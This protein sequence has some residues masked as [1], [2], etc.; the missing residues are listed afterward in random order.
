MRD[1]GRGEG[2]VDVR[3]PSSARQRH[4]ATAV[5]LPDSSLL[6]WGRSGLAHTKLHR[7]SVR[8][9]GLVPR[10]DLVAQLQASRGI[11]LVSV[12]APTGYGKTTLLAQWAAKDRRPFAWLTLDDRDND[13]AVLLTSITAALDH[14]RSVDPTVPDIPGVDRGGDDPCGGSPAEGSAQLDVATDGPRPRQRQHAQQPALHQRDRGVV[15]RRAG[16]DAS[17]ARGAKLARALARSHASRRFGSRGRT[18]RSHDERARDGAAPDRHGS[19]RSRTR[20]SQHSRSRR[21]AGQSAY[22][23]RR[24]RGGKAPATLSPRRGSRGTIAS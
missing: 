3:D 17:S 5:S 19:G 9:K 6:A 18:E 20:R 11:P 21:R 2:G 14:V 8:R 23:S 4:A 10:T 12:M 13:P 24:C 15:R 7:P 16:Q 1:T 22:I